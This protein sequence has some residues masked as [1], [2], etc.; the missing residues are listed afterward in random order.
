MGRLN[1]VSVGKY[2][3]L[4]L[5]GSTLPSNR[6][7]Q[8]EFYKDMYRE[9]IIDRVEVLKKTDVFDIEGVLQRIDTIEQLQA[10]LQQAHEQIKQLQGDIQ[11]REREI[12]HTR[13]DS[14]VKQEMLKARESAMQ[15]RKAGELYEARLGDTLKNAGA[16]AALEQEKIRMEETERWRRQQQTRK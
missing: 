12:F 9:E 6:Y 16:A 15:M 1:D 11:T 4:V 2:D 7:A 14:A 8:L 10:E 3:V 13:M 5:A